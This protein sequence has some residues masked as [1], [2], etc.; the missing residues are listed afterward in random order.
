MQ[1]TVHFIV[2]QIAY[3]L[4][5][6]VHFDRRSRM[7]TAIDT[8]SPSVT[9]QKIKRRNKITD[10]IND[11]VEDD[12][13]ANNVFKEKYS[14]NRNEKRYHETSNTHIPADQLRQKNRQNT[15]LL[16]FHVDSLESDCETS[17]SPTPPLS[18]KH[19]STYAPDFTTNVTSI[20][21][22][23]SSMSKKKNKNTSMNSVHASAF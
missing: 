3:I 19:A 2:K 22:G 7:K 8:A 20:I 13:I 10:E 12:F 4:Y 18:S 5:I 15:T 16:S 21:S 6:Y 9:F 23:P 14:K 11:M 17:D 1:V